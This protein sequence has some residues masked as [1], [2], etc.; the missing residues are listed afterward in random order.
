MKPWAL[1]ALAATILVF[2]CAPYQKTVEE[3]AAY[4]VSEA[5]AYI[6]KGEIALAGNQ[7]DIALRR[8]TG[9]LKVR[10]LFANDPKSRQLYYSYIEKGMGDIST[11]GLAA[12]AFD[13]LTTARSAGIFSD[14][15]MK[16]LFAKLEKTVTEGNESGSIAI[17]LADEIGYFPV[18]KEPHHQ[19]I[20]VERTLKL[21]QDPN[22]RNRPVKWLV[23]YIKNTSVV[24]LDRQKIETLLPT[25]N[26][27]REE[28]ELISEVFPDF[29]AARKEQLTARVFFQVKGGDRILKED[30]LQAIRAKIRGIEWA[31][32]SDQKTITLTIERL[33]HDERTQQER[34]QT[35]TYAQHEVNIIQAAL[36]MP[37]NAAYLYDVTSG[38]AEI[39]YG[40]VVTA[41]FDGKN[42]HD[43]LVRGKVGGEY[44]R[45]QN[46]RIQNVFG[47][48][49]SAGFVANSHMEQMCGG[50]QAVSIDSLRSEVYSKLVEGILKVRP[51]K[52][53]HDLN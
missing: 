17:D 16:G 52:A 39:E 51:I 5:R 22:S 12:L 41:V 15:E 40:Y 6:S 2:G 4:H 53:M 28:L 26:I 18:L 32:A 9:A 23:E 42:I 46:A 35:I 1:I 20:I 19:K 44:R 29:A 30:L 43:E 3:Q 11:A 37:R 8:Q 34:S 45:C 33:R 13:Q 50:S 31:A 14:D 25:L 48:V 47:G 38:G 24:S 21:L 7:I 36:L 10:E 49:T 27:R